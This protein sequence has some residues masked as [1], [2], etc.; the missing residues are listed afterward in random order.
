VPASS[1]TQTLVVFLLQFT[2]I[3]AGVVTLRGAE[4]FATTGS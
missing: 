4:A 3:N 2:E 1:P